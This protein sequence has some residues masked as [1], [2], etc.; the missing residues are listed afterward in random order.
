MH[1][2]ACFGSPDFDPVVCE[3]RWGHCHCRCSL[4]NSTEMAILRLAVKQMTGFFWNPVKF[5]A[6]CVAKMTRKRRCSKPLL[7]RTKLP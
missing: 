5:K 7:T 6:E 3:T 1:K 4:S 2:A